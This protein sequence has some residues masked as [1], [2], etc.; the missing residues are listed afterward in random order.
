MGIDGQ[1]AIA[2]CSLTELR[3]RLRFV[4]RTVLKGPELE[5]SKWKDLRD[6]QFKRF[7]CKEAS[8]SYPIWHPAMRPVY[9]QHPNFESSRHKS[10]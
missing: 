5:R 3:T 1:T 6:L 4:L 10:F 2:V 8:E 7:L 9:R